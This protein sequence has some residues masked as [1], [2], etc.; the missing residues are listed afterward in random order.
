MLPRC[1]IFI[2]LAVLGSI[3]L[4]LCAKDIAPQLTAEDRRL[5][6]WFD[7][8]GIEDITHARLVRVRTG[9]DELVGDAGIRQNDEPRGFLLWEKEEQFRAL[10]GDLTVATW[11]REGSPGEKNDYVG[12]RIVTPETEAEA[13]LRVLSKKTFDGFREDRHDVYTDRLDLPAQAFVLARYC[14][15]AGK[16]P[17]AARLMRAT[18]RWA[19]KGEPSQALDEYLQDAIGGALAWRAMLAMADPQLN[20]RTQ[21]L[22]FQGI[23]DHCPKSRWERIG[24]TLA[25]LR[26]M[27]EEDDAHPTISADEISRLEP[28][29]QAREWVFQL[30]NDNTQM[31][32]MWPRPWPF[33]PSPGNGATEKLKALGLA[34]VPALLAALDDD[35]PT[36]SVFR[37]QRFGGG[38]MIQTVHENAA[39]IVNDIAGVNFFWLVHNVGMIKEEERWAGM[40]ALANDWWKTTQEKGD[41]EWLRARVLAGK[42]GAEYCLEAISKRHPEALPGLVNVAIEKT[43]DPH[44]RAA[45][46]GMLKKV[47]TR[48]AIELLMN[49]LKHGP[50]L[51]A[52]NRRPPAAETVA[53]ELAACW[54]HKY[55]FDPQASPKLRATQ[56]AAIR[57]KAAR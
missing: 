22:L 27:A 20:R 6:T 26:K 10:L 25:S 48:D 34:A 57:A 35:R 55:H 23:L 50:T 8:L 17:L 47:Q 45:M 30:R 13:M 37:N 9:N 18:E 39:P 3:S 36:R 53:A 7:Q 33:D 32:D 52:S 1:T 12:W 49:E 14:V 43:K 5:F 29:D 15:A 16:E 56:L 31:A 46:V 19:R 24:A 38:A 28:A 41:I 42:E 51:G 40:R 4:A 21:A 54:P 44:A 11:K 2:Y